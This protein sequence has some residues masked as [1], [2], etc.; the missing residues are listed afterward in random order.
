M[1]KK[2]EHEYCKDAY[3]N[4]GDF[5]QFNIDLAGEPARQIFKYLQKKYPQI[6]LIKGVKLD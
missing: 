2:Q 1:T 6:K 5:E 3:K 4:W